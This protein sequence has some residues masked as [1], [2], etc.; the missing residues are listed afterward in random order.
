MQGVPRKRYDVI[1]IFF[2]CQPPIFIADLEKVHL[3]TYDKVNMNDIYTGCRMFCT[4][5]HKVWN[6]FILRST[7]NFEEKS[8]DTSIFYFDLTYFYTTM[9]YTG[10][11]ICNDVIDNFFKLTTLYILLFLN[12]KF[13][14]D[15]KDVSYLCSVVN[16]F[17]DIIILKLILNNI[18][19]ETISKVQREF[20]DRLG[21][22]QAQEG[23]QIEHLL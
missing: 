7:N 6:K 22:C 5:V 20:I 12:S 4:W 3:F 8:W 16:T 14:G 11:T 2:K 17:E 21:H 1:D 23:R 18:S 15:S 10:W 9:K 19:Q 13:Q